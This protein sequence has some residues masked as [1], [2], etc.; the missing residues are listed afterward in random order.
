MKLHLT[1][2]L[3]FSSGIKMSDEKQIIYWVFPLS[4]WTQ[5]EHFSLPKT[6]QTSSIIPRLGDNLISYSILPKHDYMPFNYKR[7]S[8]AVMAVEIT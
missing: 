1:Y 5:S 7:Y 3:K 4:P 2:Y 8:I 6:N